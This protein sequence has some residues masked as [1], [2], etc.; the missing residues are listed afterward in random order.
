M[1]TLEVLAGEKAGATF[2]LDLP[3]L[4]LG[5][6]PS[7]QVVLSDYHLSGEH[8]Q[9][10][11]EDD[12]YIY[13]DLKSTNGSR[14]RRGGTE[15]SLD[16][17]THETMLADGDELIL[18]DPSQPVVV[19]CRVKIEDEGRGKQEIIAKRDLSELSEVEGKIE[20]ERAAAL[21]NVAKKLGR[22]GL[23]LA[24]VFDGVAE[25]IF[26]QV[27]KA[28]YIAID[29]AD[30]GRMN[31]V[32][33]KSRTGERPHASRSVVRAVQREKGA[34]ILGDVG[35]ELKGASEMTTNLKSGVIGVPLWDGEKINGVIQVGGERGVFNFG[36]LDFATVVANMATLAI[37]NA[38]LVQRLRLAEEKLRGE[39]KYLKEI[40]RAHV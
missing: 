19:R 13:R 36:D 11:R 9:I 40:G 18:G 22:R 5:R 8:G 2:E 33:T 34:L 27:A 32:Y 10:F 14:V 16:D 25:A 30:D 24:S 23:D 29:L 4:T 12:R 37:E 21:Y 39:V 15:I 7:N 28:G 3:L 35:S 1:I 20:R 38:R 26:E 6:A 31:T 17:G